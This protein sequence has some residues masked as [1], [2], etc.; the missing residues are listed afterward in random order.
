MESQKQPSRL[1]ALSEGLELPTRATR[2]GK[3]MAIDGEGGGIQDGRR[4]G[5]AGRRGE[6]WGWGGAEG[7]CVCSLQVDT[8]QVSG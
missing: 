7:G 8:P 4:D 2:E 1:C 6:G 5:L 3:Q